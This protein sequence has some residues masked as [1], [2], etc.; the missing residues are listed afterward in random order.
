MKIANNKSTGLIIIISIIVPVAVA[1]LLYLPKK[2]TIGGDWVTFLPH[3]NGMLNSTTVILLLIG[4]FCVKNG[5]LSYHKTS[6]I[7][8]FILGSIFL[9][10]YII[11]HASMPS[12]SYGGET[13]LKYMY[14]FFLLTHILFSIVVV[15]FVLFA[16]YYALSGR[17]EKH[18]KIVRFTLPIWLYVSVTG[19]IVYFMISPYY[20]V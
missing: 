12:T 1:V 4:F 8:A 18:K 9:V 19:V 16:F 20:A 17:I 2:S 14:Y 7:S 13:P 11:Y 15:P 10:S 6:M 5:N 3:F